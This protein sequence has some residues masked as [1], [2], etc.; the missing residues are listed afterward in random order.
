MQCSNT[1]NLS[2]NCLN[3][4]SRPSKHRFPEFFALAD[5]VLHR[6]LSPEPSDVPTIHTGIVESRVFG[7]LKTLTW[8]GVALGIGLL[9]ATIGS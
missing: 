8:I 7:A 4:A 9:L 6:L 3:S 5:G 1:V 2:L